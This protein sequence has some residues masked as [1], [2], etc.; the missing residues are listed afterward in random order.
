MSPDVR[1]DDRPWWQGLWWCVGFYGGDIIG[2]WGL[3]FV[4]VV[5]E[6]YL[7]WWRGWQLELHNWRN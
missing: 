7:P 6:R 4:T 1:E 2:L 5:K 3:G